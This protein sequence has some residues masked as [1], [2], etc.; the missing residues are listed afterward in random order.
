[1]FGATLQAQIEANA[2]I[3]AD[4]M[5]TFSFSGAVQMA[6]MDAVLSGITAQLLL[7]E[8]NIHACMCV[9]F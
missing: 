3:K 2:L 8:G 9:M 1:M 7:R 4:S 6:D 5:F